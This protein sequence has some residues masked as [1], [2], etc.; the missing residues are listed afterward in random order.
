MSY[1]HF[2]LEPKRSFAPDTEE[3]N[4]IQTETKTRGMCRRPCGVVNKWFCCIPLYSVTVRTHVVPIG[5]RTYSLVSLEWSQVC[6]HQTDSLKCTDSWEGK[7]IC[8]S[9]WNSSS[10]AT[11]KM[12]TQTQT[13]LLNT[14]NDYQHCLCYHKAAALAMWTADLIR[15]SDSSQSLIKV[16][17][18]CS[19]T[20]SLQ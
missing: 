9:L 18:L 4:S 15:K 19:S 1:Q 16:I 5:K 17:S 10:S 14:C 11:K 2:L 12:V 3:S 8:N 13:P 6:A 7:M 20:I